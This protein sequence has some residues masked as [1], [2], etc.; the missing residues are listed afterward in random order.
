MKKAY[1]QFYPDGYFVTKRGEKVD[2]VKYN[3]AHVVNLTDLGKQLIAWHSQRPNLSYGE[4]K[5]FDK[6]FDQLFRREYAPENIQ[7]L[8]VL[9]NTLYAN[10]TRPI[11]WD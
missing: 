9:F 10:G 1:E 8:N 6:Y 3:T 4:T 2:S 7:A 11:R 5:I